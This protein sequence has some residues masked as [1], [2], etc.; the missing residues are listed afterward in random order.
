MLSFSADGSED[1]AER[2]MK[3]E[4]PG[5]LVAE[6]PA[7]ATQGAGSTTSSRRWATTTSGARVQGLRKGHAEDRDA[8][9]ERTA[10]GSGH[11]QGKEAARE[12]GRRRG[13]EP[14]LRAEHRQRRRLDD[15]ERRGQQR[16]AT[17]S[18]RRASRWPSCCTSRPEVG[19]YLSPDLLLSVQLRLQIIS[20]ATS[21]TRRHAGCGPDNV[22][23]PGTYAFAGF[24][25]ASYFFGEGDLRTYIAGNSGLG[26]IRHLATFE[27]QPKCGANMKTTCIDTV[28]VGA[29]LRRRRRRASCTTSALRSR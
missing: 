5:T 4:S 27:S 3:E 12:A 10:A 26:T 21:T 7:S 17:S 6:I 24:A 19:Y 25:R 23:S 22:C 13:P 29:R 11:P 16:R 14:L 1:F 15:G 2:E 18:T 28:A 20:G 9:A 8:G